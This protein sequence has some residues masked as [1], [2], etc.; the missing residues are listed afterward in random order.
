MELDFAKCCRGRAFWW[1]CKG[2]LADNVALGRPRCRDTPFPAHFCA[3]CLDSVLQDTAS[4]RFEYPYVIL[5]CFRIDKVL[6]N[7][8]E[9]EGGHRHY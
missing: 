1:L 4:E 3:A 8:E 9:S 7:L 6:W 5:D 2:V